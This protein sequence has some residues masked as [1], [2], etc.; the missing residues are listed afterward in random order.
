MKKWFIFAASM[1]AAVSVLSC[2]KIFPADDDQKVPITGDEEGKVMSKAE[3]FRYANS[4]DGSLDYYLL[5][6]ISDGIQINN[7]YYEGKGTIVVFDL[8]LNAADAPSLPSG[9][10]S[11][12]DDHMTFYPGSISYDEPYPTYIQIL[13][14]DEV[15]CILVKQGS[16]SISYSGNTCNIKADVSTDEG[17]EYSF[18]YTGALVVTDNFDE[19]VSLSDY[20]YGFIEYYGIDAWRAGGDYNDFSMYLSYEPLNY[21]NF[22]TADLIQLDFLTTSEATTEIPVGVYTFLEDLN[23]DSQFVAN[24]MVPG[25]VDEADNC[26]ASWLFV[27]DYYTALLEGKVEITSVSN[28]V[29]SLKLECVDEYSDEI[30]AEISTNQLEFY[31]KSQDMMQHRAIRNLYGKELTR[32]MFRRQISHR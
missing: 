10:Y 18:S 20:K 19:E 8:T 15:E 12:G 16:L 14:E 28:G 3:C 29:Y 5:T 27:G 13:G 24:R 4:E 21:D 7:E 22:D 25:Y 9:I 6:L 1:I 2:T 17:K 30:V 26:Q 31:D 32:K 23:D 11:E